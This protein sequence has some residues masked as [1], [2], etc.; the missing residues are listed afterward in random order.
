MNQF[1]MPESV[2][3]IRDY[4]QK[5]TVKQLAEA[6]YEGTPHLQNL[7][8]KLARQH[9]KAGALSFFNRMGED[10]QNFWMGIAQQ[11]I[12]NAKEWKE[13]NGCSCVLS[14]KESKR[15]KELPRHPEL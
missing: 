7:A 11:L 4:D 3:V 1:K 10:I 13:N 2:M 6:L 9:S 15:L 5:L 8:E 14:D 12:D